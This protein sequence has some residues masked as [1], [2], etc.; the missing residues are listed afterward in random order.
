MPDP[1]QP[2][3][4]LEWALVITLAAGAGAFIVVACA[5]AAGHMLGWWAP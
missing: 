4:P 5:I 1:D 2:L 3:H